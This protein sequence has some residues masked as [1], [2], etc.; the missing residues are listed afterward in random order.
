LSERANTLAACLF[1]SIAAEAQFSDKAGSK[2]HF[3]LM[4]ISL[5]ELQQVGAQSAHKKKKATRRQHLNAW[6]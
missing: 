6:E 4:L 2:S 1:Y 3:L 5:I